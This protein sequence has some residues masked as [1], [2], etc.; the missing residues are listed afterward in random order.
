LFFEGNPAVCPSLRGAH[1]DGQSVVAIAYGAI[2][3]D[4]SPPPSAG[5]D[6][7]DHEPT[8]PPVFA[9]YSPPAGGWGALRATARALR[10]QS[11]ELKGSRTLLSMNQPD[12]FDCP[13]CAWP[14]PRHTSSFEFCENGAK[15]VTW[16]LTK[17]RVTREFFATH[18]V[19]E[20]EQE[21]DYWLEQQGRLTEPMRYDPATDHYVPVGWDDAFALVARELNALHDPNEAEFYTSARTIFRIARTCATSRPVSA[22]PKASGSARGP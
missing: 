6:I 20:L 8:A 7:P 21:S 11:V 9:P 12:G 16:E 22:F 19:R 13:G 2:M 14:D 17:H 3:T 4:Q 15:A 1:S 10:G 5:G 18:T